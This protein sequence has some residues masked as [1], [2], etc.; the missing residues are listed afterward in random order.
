LSKRTNEE[1]ALTVFQEAEEF[2]RLYLKNKQIENYPID[3]KVF[4]E[5]LQAQLS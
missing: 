1:P 2:S 4:V 5:N 3:L